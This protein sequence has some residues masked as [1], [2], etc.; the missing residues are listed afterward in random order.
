M[1][2]CFESFGL[3]LPAPMIEFPFDS[4]RAIASL[5]YSQALPRRDKINFIFSHGGGPISFLA[6]RMTLI[7]GTPLV[8]ARALS[9]DQARQWLARW[10]YDLTLIGSPAEVSVLKAMAPTSQLL[11]GTDYPFSPAI[12]ARM[13]AGAFPHL[14]FD[15]AEQVQVLHGNAARLFPAFGRNCGCVQ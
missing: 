15:A 7:G 9:A 14:P 11:Y 3:G 12:L 5:L 8:G 2:C 10:H 13:A 6:S 1:P 4:T